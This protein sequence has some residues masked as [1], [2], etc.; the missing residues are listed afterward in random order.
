MKN[1][2]KQDHPVTDATFCSEKIQ[3]CT[4]FEP[5]TFYGV[6]YFDLYDNKSKAHALIDQLAINH[7][8]IGTRQR[9]ASTVKLRQIK[10]ISV[11][12]RS[13]MHR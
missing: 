1:Y 10:K 13:K 6:F 5:L 7:L 11:L 8:P 12:T 4:G 3:V 9:K 2:M